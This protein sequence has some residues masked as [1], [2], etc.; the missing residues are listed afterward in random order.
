[1]YKQISLHQAQTLQIGQKRKWFV[2]SEFGGSHGFYSKKDMDM[3]S[4]ST[5]STN[6]R[7]ST[8]F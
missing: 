1:M 7:D 8:K 5:I 3:G 2:P 4:Y 6:T